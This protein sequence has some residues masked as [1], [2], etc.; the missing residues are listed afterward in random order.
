MISAND[1]FLGSEPGPVVAGDGRLAWGREPS[2]REPFDAEPDDVLD[3]S[4]TLFTG[5]GLVYETGRDGTTGGLSVL[6]E[7]SFAGLPG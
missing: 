5:V 6:C 7:D 3:V 2:G 4:E 1:F